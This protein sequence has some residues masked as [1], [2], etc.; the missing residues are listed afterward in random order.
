MRFL[1][2]EGLPL[3]LAIFLKE[4]GHDVTTV[5]KTY[6]HALS[7]R[8]VL[9]AAQ[10]EHRV[11]LTN[12]KDFGELIFRDHLPHAG[13]ILFRVGYLP[14]TERITLIKRVL[15]EHTDDLRHFVVVTK[16]RVRVRRT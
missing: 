5:G 10:Q 12:D 14:I 7:D 15:T 1:L 9:T 13:V 6:P 16:S 4:Q 2:D 3:R 8:A 11:L